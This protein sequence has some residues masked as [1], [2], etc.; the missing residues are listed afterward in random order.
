MQSADATVNISAPGNTRALSGVD[1]QRIAKA[2]RAREPIAEAR[3]SGRWCGTL[4]PT[5]ALAQQAGMSDRDY[6]TFVSRA[7]FLD[8][9]DPLGAGASSAT[10]SAS[11]WSA[12]PTRVKSTSR[13]RALT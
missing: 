6:D 11:W 12:C 1:P 8:R 9:A 4:W 5:S 10:A 3:L 13:R 2:A 7:L